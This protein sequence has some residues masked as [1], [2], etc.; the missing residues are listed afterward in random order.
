MAKIREKVLFL[1]LTMLLPCSPEVKCQDGFVEHFLVYPKYM[2]CVLG[3]FSVVFPVL[4]VGVQPRMPRG[5]WGLLVPSKLTTGCSRC[6]G[7]ALGCSV[8]GGGS[9][10]WPRLTSPLN[11]RNSNIGP[12]N[13]WGPVSQNC[14]LVCLVEQCTSGWGYTATSQFFILFLNFWTRFWECPQPFKAG[15]L[16]HLCLIK[17]G[18]VQSRFW[19]QV[20]PGLYKIMSL[21][22]AENW[23][24][25]ECYEWI[26]CIGNERVKDENLIAQLKSQ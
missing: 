14:C 6:W 11:K 22:L 24:K 21:D 25:A 5:L 9:V 8:C 18:E 19:L 12:G 16:Q 2:P 3:S 23:R 26:N 20:G 1:P 13:S 15:V 4:V 17:S 10:R 7:A